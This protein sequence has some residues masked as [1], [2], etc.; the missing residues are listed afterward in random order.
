MAR[1]GKFGVRMFALITVSTGILSGCGDSEN[2]VFTNSPAVGPSVQAPVAND[3]T[4]TAL[5]NATL[6]QAVATAC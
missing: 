1:I 2:F 5:G 3:D 6:R 4:V